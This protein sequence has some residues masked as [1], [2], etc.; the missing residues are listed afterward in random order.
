MTGK[1]KTGA[2]GRE[3]VAELRRRLAEAEQLLD[4]ERF[5][6]TLLEQA[7][8]AVLACDASGIIITASERATDL[9]GTNLVGC[10]LDQVCNR[11]VPATD[12]EG[13]DNSKKSPVTFSAI[14][15]GEV[16][17]GIEVVL[18]GAHTL[19]RVILFK[20]SR[21]MEGSVT[22]GYFILLS[23]ITERKQYEEEL[24]RKA[25]DLETLKGRLEALNKELESFS[26]SVSHDLRA[27]LRALNGFSEIILQDYNDV[28][29]ER[30]KEYLARIRKA[31]QTMALLIDDMLK[32]SRVTRAEM[33]LTEVNLGEM[34]RHILAEL[35]AAFP[36]QDLE[37]EIDPDMSVYADRSLME[38]ALRNIFSNAWK[39]T[40]RVPRTRI[41]FKKNL[42]KGKPVYFVRDNGVGFNMRYVDRL[43]QPFQRLHSAEEYPGSGI[44]LATVQ[45][46]I[47]RHGGDIWAESELGRGATFYFT[48]KTVRKKKLTLSC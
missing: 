22:R 26:Y 25:E 16:K 36:K 8:N 5:A 34:A 42:I 11:I 31:S 9:L 39:F 17:S 12:G 30:G 46:I 47:R 19:P 44:G 41:E 37:V 32:L 28:L 3:N 40:S 24:R 23:D 10:S 20:Y 15:E 7:A 1:A 38:I 21:V 13:T 35:N 6:R 4:S 48:L 29:D 27:P 43:F 2:F 14:R 45:R 18:T 33:Q